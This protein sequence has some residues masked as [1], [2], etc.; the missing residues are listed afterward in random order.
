MTTLSQPS[1]SAGEITPETWG[2]V[3]MDM[4]R[5]GVAKAE[6]FLV[7]FHGGMQR[8]PGMKLIGQ[9]NSNGNVVLIPFQFSTIQ[10]YMIEVSNLKIRIIKDGGFVTDGVNIIEVDVPYLDAELDRITFTQSADVLTIFHQNHQIGQLKRF[11]EDDWRYELFINEKGPFESFNINKANKMWASGQDGV[12]TITSNFDAFNDPEHVGKLLSLEQ[13]TSGQISTW[14]Q[15][16]AVSV[17]DRTYYAGRYYICTEARLYSG[18]AAQTGDTPPT[19]TESDQWDGPNQVL[20]DDNRNAYIGVK[21][22]YLHSGIGIVKIDSVTSPTEVIATVIVTVPETMVGGTTPAQSWTFANETTQRVFTVSPAF[23]TNLVSDISVVLKDTSASPI[24]DKPLQYPNEFVVN[25]ATNEVTLLI[26]PGHGDPIEPRDVVVSQS[27]SDRDTYKWAFEP[28]RST[29]KYPQCGTYYQQRFSMAATKALPQTLWMSRT[30][31]FTD[32]STTRPSLADDSMRFDVN[33]LQVNEILHMLP[34]NALLLFTSGGV[35]SIN[36]GSNDVISPE[37]PPNVRI[38]SYDGS[39]PIRP[40]VTGSSGLYVQDGQQVIR[41]IGFD[42]SSDAYIGVDLTVRATHL[43]QGRK[44]VSWCYAKNPLKVIAVTFDDGEFAILTYMK[45][46]QL[47]GWC[48]GKTDGNVKWISSV[49]EGL[50]D[51]VY[52]VVERDGVNYIERLME[53]GTLDADQFFVDSGLTYD[54][55][56]TA[57]INVTMTALSWGADDPVTLAS[58]TDLFTVGQ[59][60]LFDTGTQRAG[61]IIDSITD[62]KNATGTIQQIIPEEFRSVATDKFGVALNQVSGLNHLEGKTVQILGDAAVMSDQVVTA[63]AVDLD[64]YAVVIH[65]GLPFESTLQTLD[66]EL[67]PPPESARMRKKLISKINIHV[68]KTASFKAGTRLDKLETPRIRQDENYSFPERRRNGIAEMAISS[69]W[70]KHGRFYV[71]Q[72]KP[73]NLSI[74]SLLPEVTV[75]EV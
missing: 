12:I 29:P 57:G 31:S 63:G 28:W 41:D 54:G 46:Q 21:W 73:I 19:H 9:A 35:W 39:S 61:V 56:N 69:S 26:D 40:I 70:D 72:D 64:N 1:M 14:V 17:G 15:R 18:K 48:S 60:L 4:Y 20:P 71:V 6:N 25:F 36:Q 38:Q 30:D 53:L 75:S 68:D 34:L 45:E 13:K 5:L 42:F 37:T 67:A 23:T 33:S 44:I 32:F 58:D 27:S 50:E 65:A 3:D 8:R 52:A 22:K 10:T 24:P 2:R 66:M 49:R 16:M 55:R 62:A 51:T 43:F 59:Y 7:N 11:A 47:W 74:L